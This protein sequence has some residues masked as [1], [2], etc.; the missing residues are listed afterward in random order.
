MGKQ[1]QTEVLPDHELGLVP[2]Q[3][4]GEVVDAVFG[5]ATE[6]GPNFRNVNIFY[7]SIVFVEA[8]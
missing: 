4:E 3:Q 1:E 5:A 2:T 8:N 6:D 7:R